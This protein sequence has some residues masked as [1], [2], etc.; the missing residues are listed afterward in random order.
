MFCKV[1]AKQQITTM[2]GKITSPVKSKVK[3][4]R[5]S[6]EV[7]LCLQPSSSSLSFDPGI[8]KGM[9]V[10]GRKA[11]LGCWDEGAVLATVGA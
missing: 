3:L 9:S 2:Q 7:G 10:W 6:V 1:T 5:N 11:Y 4:P 8:P